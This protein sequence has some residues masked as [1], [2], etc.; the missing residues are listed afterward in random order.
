MIYSPF[1]QQNLAVS[2]APALSARSTTASSQQALQVDI[3]QQKMTSL[4]ADLPSRGK[5]HLQSSCTLQTS[6]PGNCI[7]ENQPKD[8]MNLQ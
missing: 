5:G 1:S 4:A 6:K 8:I 2:E 3:V 7:I